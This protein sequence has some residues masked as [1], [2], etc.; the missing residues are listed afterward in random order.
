MVEDGPLKFDIYHI[1]GCFAPLPLYSD[2]SNSLR[3]DVRTINRYRPGNVHAGT[4][5]LPVQ[6]LLGHYSDRGRLNVYGR[7]EPSAGRQTGNAFP[8][9]NFNIHTNVFGQFYK[10]HLKVRSSV[11]PR[12]YG[13]TLGF[14][15]YARE[16]VLH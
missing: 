12:V 11:T 2:V 4:R 15:R 13:A 1:I 5:V 7:R 3:C 6:V 14:V 10:R 16:R 8:S 9:R